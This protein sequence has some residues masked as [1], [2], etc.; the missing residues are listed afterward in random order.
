[1]IDYISQ[2]L[3][4][5]KT[6]R[7]KSFL[8]FFFL[9]VF[10]SGFSKFSGF[11][12]IEQTPRKN[13]NSANMFAFLKGKDKQNLEKSVTLIVDDV[14]FKN[15]TQAVS[16]EDYLLE[17]KIDLKDDMILSHSLD[18]L[19]Q[20]NSVFTVE[21]LNEHYRYEEVEIPIATEYIYDCDLLVGI[22]RVEAQG[23]KGLVKNVYKQQFLGTELYSDQLAE[24]IELK[25][26]EPKIIRAGSKTSLMTPEGSVIEFTRAAV[27]STTG[28][29]SCYQC[30]GKNPGDYGYGIT[31]S[32]L[33]QGVGVV[34]VDPR[35]IPYG[36]KMYVE[37]Y[38]YAVA[39]DTGGAII[40]NHLDLGFETHDDAIVW[41][42]R[43][44]W[45][46][47]LID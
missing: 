10:L 34:G 23:Q 27:L 32:G 19:V 41:A 5:L 40:P 3:L 36:T 1:M 4:K 14:V 46:Y 35:Y 47:F 38:G 15:Q 20:S 43:N 13:L 25:K 42:L 17:N 12:R 29:C 9:L 24:E 28:Y 30:C 7:A 11:N 33:P 22:E 39:G 2:M 21:H 16:L 8:V 6:K 26:M 31:A 18:T 44:S 37:G 45:V